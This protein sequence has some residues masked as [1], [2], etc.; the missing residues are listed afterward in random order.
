M[1]NKEFEMLTLIIIIF[2]I[3]FTIT[4]KEG[5]VNRDRIFGA[6]TVFAGMYGYLAIMK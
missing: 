1:S 4:D 5:C 2:C 6:A 3:Y